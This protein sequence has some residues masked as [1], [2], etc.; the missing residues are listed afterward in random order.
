MY[1]EGLL[2]V[3]QFGSECVDQ[4]DGGCM[5]RSCPEGAIAQVAQHESLELYDVF[6]GVSWLPAFSVPI[7]DDDLVCYEVSRLAS[8]AVR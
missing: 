6:S 4:W 1:G 5:E 7:H 3:V 8:G 2:G